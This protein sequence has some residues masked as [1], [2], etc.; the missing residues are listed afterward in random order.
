MKMVANKMHKNLTPIFI[1]SCGMAHEI[2]IFL[3]APIANY[4][5]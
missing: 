1:F 5:W 2:V 3:I 4:L